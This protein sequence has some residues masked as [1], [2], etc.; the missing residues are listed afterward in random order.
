MAAQFMTG[1]PEE[2][3]ERMMQAVPGFRARKSGIA[4]SRVESS[5]KCEKVC[6]RNAP[7]SE[8]TSSFASEINEKSLS[9]RKRGG[10]VANR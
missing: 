9:A 4:V 8:L 7:L 5:K 1:T 3:L 2:G 6:Q 10:D